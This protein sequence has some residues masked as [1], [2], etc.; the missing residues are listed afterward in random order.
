[1][2]KMTSFFLGLILCLACIGRP[3]RLIASG[4]FPLHPSLAA[5]PS[6]ELPKPTGSHAVGTVIYNWT[7]ITREDIASK[8]PD[9]KRQLVIQL[10]YPA[11]VEKDAQA[12]PYM[13]ELAVLRAVYQQQDADRLARIRT[14]AALQAK[15]SK[16]RVKYP[17]IVFSHGRGTPRSYYTML[18]EEIASHGYV[19][20]GIDHPYVGRVAVNG[21]VAPMYPR[22]VDPPAGG[23]RDKTD[24]ER[25]RYWSESDNLLSVDQRFVLDQLAQLSRDDPDKR[26]TGRLDMDHVGMA[27]HSK[28]FVS[29]TCGRDIRFKACLNLDGVPALTERENGFRQPF[30]TMRDGDDSPRTTTIY[31]NLRTV[32][33]DVLIRGSGHNSYLDLPLLAEFE[34]KIEALRSRRIINAY[35]LAFFDTYLKGKKIL[36]LEQSSPDFPEV[37]FTIYNPKHR[38]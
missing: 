4:K 14:N 29:Q 35:M 20:A 1:M 26:F 10:W 32:G 2:F 9:D 11:E 17:V 16:A 23:L 31:E 30:M 38:K 28:G 19:V 12:A 33:Y 5:D 15:L 3:E 37:T 7:D 13:P 21:K 6:I 25:D 18:M 8:A 24:E 27:G 36:L 34:Y 22:W